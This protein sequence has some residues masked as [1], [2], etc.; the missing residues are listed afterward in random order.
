MTA[1]FPQRSQRRVR[2]RVFG[3]LAAFALLAASLCPPSETASPQQAP[4]K[5]LWSSQAPSPTK[6]D[7]DRQRVVNELLGKKP[8]SKPVPIT[9]GQSLTGKLKH[10]DVNSYS[11]HV[12]KGQF[13]RA[14]VFPSNQAYLTATLYDPAGV[15]VAHAYPLASR[16][17]PEPLAAVAKATGTYVFRISRPTVEDPIGRATFLP[18]IMGNPFEDV[19]PE[20]AS[21]SEIALTEVRPASDADA[22]WT[23]A[24]QLSTQAAV[25]WAN[26]NY[27][28]TIKA[29]KIWSDAAALW[30]AAGDQAEL[31][32]SLYSAAKAYEYHQ[33]HATAEHL[34][35]QALPIFH[36]LRYS[37]A[38]GL[39]LNGLGVISDELGEKNQALDDYAQ[40][41]AIFKATRDESNE[42]AAENDIGKV[43]DTTG[44]KQRALDSYEIALLC[45]QDAENAYQEA[46]DVNGEAAVR[47]NIGLVYFSLGDY[48][49][50]ETRLAYASDL[51]LGIFNMSASANVDNAQAIVY[52]QRK[53][54]KEAIASYSSALNIVPKGDRETA[55][56]LHNGLCAAFDE[57]GD[58]RSAIGECTQGLQLFKDINDPAGQAQSLESLGHARYALGNK[59]QARENYELALANFQFVQDPSGESSVLVDLM[60]YAQAAGNR[61]LAILFGKQAV[62]LFQQIRRNIQSMP[63]R[64]HQAFIA[65]TEG[66][67]RELAGLLVDE[68]RFPE[69]E[70][71]LDM[72]KWQ[73]FSDYVNRGGQPDSAIV[74]PPQ[75]DGETNAAAPGKTIADSVA[76]IEYA[77]SGLRREANRSAADQASFLQYS[78]QIEKYNVDYKNY[79]DGLFDS[80]GKQI[81]TTQTLS[82]QRKQINDSLDAMKAGSRQ[83]KSLLVNAA[84]GT[85]G[86]YTLILPDRCIL[87]VTTPDVDI[88]HD[89]TISSLSLGNKIAD[90]GHLFDSPPPHDNLQ[91]KSE[92]LYKLL[93]SPIE[94]D[95]ENLHAKTLIWSL[96][97]A[98]RY[99]PVAA[100]YD[101]KQYLVERYALAVMNTTE[102]TNLAA[103]PPVSSW[104]GL[105]M[106][107]SRDYG[108]GP[109]NAV[110][111]ELDSVVISPDVKDSHGPIPGA[112]MLND[113]FTEDSMEDALE[114]HPR[115]VHIATH[116]VFQAGNDEQSFLLLGNDK[117]SSAGEHLS[118][119]VMS[120]APRI[121]FTGVELLTLSGCQTALGSN[122]ASNGREIDSLGITGETR[123]AKAVLATLWKVDDSSNALLMGTFYRLL[124]ATP[125]ITKAEALRQ[126]ELVLLHGTAAST[127]YRD[128]YFWAPFVLMG[129]WE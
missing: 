103:A 7:D 31:A 43:Y 89:I 5:V 129:N 36:S 22:S 84:P 34:Y 72:L 55:G 109:L 108:L 82:D 48:D 124:S 56:T 76:S 49:Q 106:G 40:A 111:S 95:L 18:A 6:P 21:A 128:P 79:L 125:G 9:A 127:Q 115:L 80:Y 78:N 122:A 20:Q 8:L 83:L 105:A 17:L 23:K 87:I 27:D 15:P 120:A 117:N 30:Q 16:E 19:K 101:G 14:V 39:T 41:L 33:Q 86:I 73:E 99:L 94:S 54:Y 12:E 61:P 97:G 50:A 46:D 59:T 74:N 47:A 64:E 42:A 121:D 38:E 62:D 85:V 26:D 119:A 126:A 67:Y 57:S 104:R 113:K 112:I 107:T 29:Q 35:N 93:V 3:P 24:Q 77:Y 92:D 44:Q 68:G 96:D 1:V 25:L 63:N 60:T 88:P 32:L 91:A 98:L 13:V 51:L 102:S 45:Y 66:A 37:E 110:P 11:I 90:F 114:Q 123:G 118:L 52:R 100:L 58:H 81:D 71:I 69:A 10:G 2:A 53:K 4:V 116:F 65:R 70:Q 28:S 75:T